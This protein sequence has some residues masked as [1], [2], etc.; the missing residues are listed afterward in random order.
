MLYREERE[1]VCE[2]AKRMW[3]AGLVV[4]SAGNVSVRAP[5]PN[6]W[7]ITPSSIA[8][9][10][11]T[12]DQVVVVDEES[13]LVEGE[14]APSFETPIHL[15]IYRARPDVGAVVH[16]H[17]RHA[18]TM[19]LLRRPIPPVLDEMVVYLGGPV[20]VAHYGTSGSDALAANV[21]TAL[22]D[23]S[24]V[25][26]AAHG[27]LTT[28]KDLRKAYK[29][30]ELVEHVAQIVLAASAL[31]GELAPLPDDVLEAEKEMYEIVKGM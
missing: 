15:A 16:T 11:L 14:R 4:G 5:D 26:L 21:V 9:D 29:N 7:V 27:V 10:E 20:E 3:K 28:G 31:G 1:L 30:A 22:G 18:T 23:R 19:A 17:S 25:L 12:A 13:D 24:A 2:T 6:R 8:Y